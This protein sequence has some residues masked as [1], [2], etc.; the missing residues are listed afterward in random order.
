M[1]VTHVSTVEVPIVPRGTLRL[2]YADPPY[3]GMGQRLYSDPTYDDIGAHRGLVEHLGGFDGW[4]MSLSS[5]TL[6]QILPLCPAG[7]RVMAWVKPMCSF[8]PGV[9]P[10][11]S[12]EPVIVK[13]GRNPPRGGLTIR[14]YLSCPAAFGRGL[15]GA[16]PD[17]FAHWI[18]AV[19]GAQPSDSF[20]D[21]FPGT[22]G[23]GR[24]WDAFRRQHW[25]SLAGGGIGED[26]NDFPPGLPS[27]ESAR[28]TSEP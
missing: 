27:A 10:A 25:L 4:A 22:G 1:G 21:L 5:T 12:W 17:A 20:T 2:A 18:F 6:S 3:L 26:C 23:V 13:V 15:R 19:L 28:L 8:K 11:Y 16:K 24:S 9:N 14:D 7:V